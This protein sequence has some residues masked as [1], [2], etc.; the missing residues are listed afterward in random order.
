LVDPDRLQWEA[1]LLF[2]YA[3]CAKSKLGLIGAWPQT[4]Q[5]D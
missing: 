4:K 5:E 3:E 1:D 2:L